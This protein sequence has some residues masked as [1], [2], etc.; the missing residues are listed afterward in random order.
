MTLNDIVW[1]TVDSAPVGF[2]LSASVFVGT[3][4]LT[5]LLAYVSSKML[6][7][8]SAYIVYCGVAG[9]FLAAISGVICKC[10]KYVVVVYCFL[11]ILKCLG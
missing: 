2:I 4:L 7:S 1:S 9:S 11:L 3:L 6:V 5:I 8:K 10:S